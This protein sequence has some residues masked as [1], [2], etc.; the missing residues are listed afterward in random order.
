M[1]EDR[2]RIETRDH[3][4]V[5]TLTRA[6]KHNALDGAMFE[7]I[8]G[9]AERVAAQPGV[10][11]VVLHGDGP[12]F[13]SGLDVASLMSAPSGLDGLA[14]PR[15]AGESPN[16][17]QRRGLRLGAPADAGDRGAARQL[18][19][20]R[21]PDRARRRHPLRRARR[22]PLGDGGQVGPDPRHV[23]HA[24]PP[25]ARLAIDVAKELTY[26]GRVFSG[27]EA[28]AARTGHPRRRRSARTA[29]SS[30]PPRSPAARP[31]RYAAPSGCSTRPGSAEAETLALEAELQLGLIGSPNQLAAVTAGVTKQPAQFADP[32]A[33]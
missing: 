15:S 18:P 20:R 33:A 13:C 16:W 10:R 29:R 4:A 6:E 31:T 3:V 24:N 8:I 32:P 11:A 12:S 5:V 26:T 22:A 25:P 19:R 17:F 30:S 7:G 21:S 27:S 14:R 2:V 9:A 23:D 1:S 28:A